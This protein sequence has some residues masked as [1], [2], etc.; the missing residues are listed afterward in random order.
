[1]SPSGRTRRMGPWN[2]CGLRLTRA[3]TFFLF[4]FYIFRLNTLNPVRLSVD[5]FGKEVFS[6]PRGQ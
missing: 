5:K 4:V 2:K 3:H 1:M 6:R